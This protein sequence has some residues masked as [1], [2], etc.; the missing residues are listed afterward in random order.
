ME[1][2]IKKLPKVKISE[3][4]YLPT[5]SGLFFVIDNAFRVW[6]VGT[7]KSLRETLKEDQMY[8]II[9]NTQVS[10][11]A[12]FQWE[13]WEDLA[14]WE[15]GCLRKFN[16]PL[17]LGTEETPLPIADLG[18]NQ[19]QYLARYKEIQDLIRT[20]E[21]EKEELKPNII[22]LLE[23]NGGKIHSD[24]LKAWIST[25]KS[26]SYSPQL[27]SMRRSIAEMQKDEELSEV[28]QVK[29][30]LVFPVVKGK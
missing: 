22:S 10:Q 29:S 7:A 30:V 11:I 20:L 2:K 27:E 21:Q 15:I 9:T 1:F 23:E 16:P 18:Y 28:A 3:I 14:D 12:Y 13:D 6:Y 19:S 26:Y 5:T 4:E 8:S 17:N 25:R 24:T